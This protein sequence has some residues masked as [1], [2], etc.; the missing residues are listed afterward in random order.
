[1]GFILFMIFGVLE[2][3]AL[4]AL[5]FNTFRLTYFEYIKEIS[6]ISI[7]V[8]FVSYIIRVHFEINMFVD[9]ATHLILYILFFRYLIKAKVWRSII[10]SLMYIGYGVLSTFVF[11]LLTLLKVVSPERLISNP[12]SISAYS[13]QITTAIISLLVSYLIHKYNLGFSFIIRP[14]HDFLIKNKIAKHDIFI[15]F[16]IAL[17][18]IILFV[19]MYIVFNSKSFASIPII[20]VSYLVLIYLAYKRDMTI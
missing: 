9:I 13:V 4:F 18:L 15:I 7:T 16:A 12:N 17:V 2:I 6:I 14:P 1:M 8:S 10:I 11:F 19:T 20:I 3:Y 5:M